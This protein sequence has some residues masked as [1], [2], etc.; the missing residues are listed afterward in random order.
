MVTLVGSVMA[1]V[2]AAA[3]VT[4]TVCV[5]LSRVMLETAAL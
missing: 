2:G 3:R 4:V 5:A 1:G